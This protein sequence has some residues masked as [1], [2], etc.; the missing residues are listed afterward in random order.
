MTREMGSRGKA[1]ADGLA[2]ALG[3][4]VVHHELV[5]RHIAERL[6][7]GESAVHRFL[8]GQS[9]MLDRW[10]IDH[11]K[12][13]R[14]TAEEVL[15]IAMKGNVL[16]R[17]WGAAQLLSDVSHVIC[18]RV[19]APMADRIAEMSRRLG[20]DDHRIVAREIERNDDA[21]ERT[22]QR[23][24]ARDWRDPLVYD[25]VLNT[26]RMPIDACIAQLQSLAAH[27]A[28]QETPASLA[29]LKD[30]LIEARVR[31]I[32]DIEVADLPYGSGL[33]VAV[34][35]GVVTLSGVV[36]GMRVHRPVIDRAAK[37]DGV[38]NVNDEVVVVD[39]SYGL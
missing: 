10:K 35:D 2:N 37:L 3:L 21:H 27:P 14:V 22:V 11:K 34:S 33:H 36:T 12:L 6:N 30:K 18:V 32:L 25:I 9:T 7:L 4:E 1:V 20:I 38:V 15:Q 19:C 13:S 24:F 28:Y 26:G 5:E 29:R 17:G 8:E 16:I 31:T 23:Q 39:Q